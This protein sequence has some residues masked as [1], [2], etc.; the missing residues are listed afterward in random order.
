MDYYKI[1]KWM[2]YYKNGLLQS[3]VSLNP[4]ELSYMGLS[5]KASAKIP[6]AT[7][8]LTPRHFH[9]NKR[10]TE[11]KNFLTVKFSA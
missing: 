6:P 9:R 10:K 5:P 4:S 7:M 8:S 2:D 1:T 3:L 11:P